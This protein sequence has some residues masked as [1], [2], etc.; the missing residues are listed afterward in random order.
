MTLRAMPVGDLSPGRATQADSSKGR[1]LTKSDPLALQVWGLG[2]GLITQSHKKV[3]N[4]ETL[5]KETITTGCDGPPESLNVR[6]GSRKE[7]TN[8]MTL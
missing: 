3:F 5:A 6:S 2:T 7:A 8:R 1:G 4:T